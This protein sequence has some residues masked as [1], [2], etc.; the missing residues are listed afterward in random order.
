MAETPNPVQLSSNSPHNYQDKN[1]IKSFIKNMPKGNNIGIS[2][3]C[4]K[5]VDEM[6][7]KL[8]PVLKAAKHGLNCRIPC[9]FEAMIRVDMQLTC[10]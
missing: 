7:K 5:E 2:D 4:P 6:R 3:D 1:F 9:H 10:I 8:Y